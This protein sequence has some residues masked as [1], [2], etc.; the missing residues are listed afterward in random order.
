MGLDEEGWVGCVEQGEW[1]RR[2][3]REGKRDVCVHLH[4]LELHSS[5]V[6]TGSD[7]VNVCGTD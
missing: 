7:C 3:N 1:R 4:L 5:G 2:T 6:S